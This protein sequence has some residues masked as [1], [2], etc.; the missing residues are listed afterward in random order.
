MLVRLLRVLV[1]VLRALLRLRLGRL[2]LLQ[3]QLQGAHD[4]PRLPQLRLRTR[5][6]PFVSSLVAH[7]GVGRAR[8]TRRLVLLESF[9]T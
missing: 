2:D 3:L 7:A 4:P 9:A 8:V 6:R 1:R 5:G